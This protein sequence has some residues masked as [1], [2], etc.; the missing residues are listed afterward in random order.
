MYSRY[1]QATSRSP[2]GNHQH[3]HHTSHHQLHE[4]E[5]IYE[6]ADQDRGSNHR[7]ETPDSERYLSNL[8]L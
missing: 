6:T 8:N 3:N 5:G 2:Y 7:G 1:R 4:D